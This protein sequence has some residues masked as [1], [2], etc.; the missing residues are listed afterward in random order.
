MKGA[1]TV[2]VAGVVAYLAGALLFLTGGSQRD[3]SAFE[4]GSAFNDTV[5]GLSLA[6]RYLGARART[7]ARRLEPDAIEHDAAVL[8]FRPRGRVKDK[9]D[10]A[11]LTPA[12]LAW[13]MAGGRLVLA[14][15]QTRGPVGTRTGQAAPLVK[16]LPVWPGV[17]RFEP[18][19]PRVLGA[20]LPAGTRTLV[21]RGPDALIARWRHGRGEVVF[22]AA[23]EALE[24][25]GLARG[26]HLG[27]LEALAAGRSA[28]YFDEFAHGLR[29][30]VD[31]LDMLTRWGFGPTLMAVVLVAGL[32]L[33]RETVR[34]GPADAD[35][36]EA[37]ADAVDLLDSLA[38]LYDRAL[39]G[40]EA[41]RLYRQ[42]LSRRV[43]HETGLRGDALAARVGEMVGPAAQAPVFPRALHA[44]NE[45]YRRLKHAQA[46]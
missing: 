7:L 20:G 23:P 43:A 19:T 26:D 25:G 11:I 46:R 37:P 22:L 30:N 1:R 32:A 41:L 10:N 28:V 17:A 31:A 6:H 2:L 5:S 16:V 15:D 21:A 12:E 42:H 24:N 18:G 33:W 34:V 14:V 8:R 44:L 36:R 39:G 3:L 35:R 13:V 29:E 9:D 40:Q 38:Q 4:P 45:G 27:L